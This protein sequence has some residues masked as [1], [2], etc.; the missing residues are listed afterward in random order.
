M[1]IEPWGSTEIV[2]IGLPLTFMA[3]LAHGHAL[4][5]RNSNSPS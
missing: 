4:E 1:P 2:H 5:A 3:H